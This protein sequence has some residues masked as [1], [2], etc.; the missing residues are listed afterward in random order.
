[1]KSAP[2]NISS[3]AWPAPGNLHD[4]SR[5]TSYEPSPR[6]PDANP[7]GSPLQPIDERLPLIVVKRC[8][9]DEFLS[10][11][12][13][14]AL[15]YSGSAEKPFAVPVTATRSNLLSMLSRR[16]CSSASP[17][18]CSRTVVSFQPILVFAQKIAAVIRA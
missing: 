4:Q 5:F 18:L 8:Y 16:D 10:S 9:Y 1:M 12:V 13:T 14:R 15:A 2:I 6:L 11:R 3:R 7:N 17:S